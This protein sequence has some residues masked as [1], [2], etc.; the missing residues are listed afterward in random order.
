M[1]KQ[2][3]QGE[4]ELKFKENGGMEQSSKRWFSQVIE[5]EIGDFFIQKQF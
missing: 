4:L 5:E 2:V 3:H 1:I